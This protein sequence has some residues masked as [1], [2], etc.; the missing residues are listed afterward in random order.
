MSHLMTELL[1]AARKQLSVFRGML[2][3]I[4]DAALLSF[5]LVAMTMLSPRYR[6]LLNYRAR[7]V[8]RWQLYGY[9]LYCH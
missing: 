5:T 8:R 1:T 7:V 9:A 2:K 3:H 4:T 6:R